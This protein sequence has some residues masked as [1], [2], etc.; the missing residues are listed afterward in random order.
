MLDA[1]VHRIVDTPD[2]QWRESRPRPTS[3]PPGYTDEVQVAEWMTRDPITLGPDAPL[4][5]AAETMA[6]RN[7]RRIPIVEDDLVVGIVTKSDVLSACPPN[8]NP[9][10]AEPG[11]AAELV[12]PV[13]QVMTPRPLV[14]RPDVPVEVAAQ[15][16][17]DN[18]IGGLPVVTDR[19]IGIL[20]ASDLFRALSVALGSGSVGLRVAFEIGA[21]EEAVPFVLQLVARHQLKLASVT[22]HQ[23]NEQRSI[24]LRLTGT[25]PPGLIDELWQTGHRVLSVLRM[26]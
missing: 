3:V 22:T 6:R 14:V 11:E 23:R 7:I 25:E 15:I 20:T 2:P 16:M 13:R 8:L 21:D 12:E 5:E 19:L 18:K 1:R 4:G 9:F 10:S 26:K 17:I 24:I